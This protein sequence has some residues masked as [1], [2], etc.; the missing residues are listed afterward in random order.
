VLTNNDLRPITAKL[1]RWSVV[2]FSRKSAAQTHTSGLDG[3]LRYGVSYLILPVL[4][5]LPFDAISRSSAPSIPAIH[6]SSTPLYATPPVDK[7]V[8]TLALSVEWPTVG[9]HYHEADTTDAAG[10][11]ID[12][13][14]SNTTEY[15][16]YYDAESCYTYNNATEADQR[17]FDRSGA[18]TNRMCDDAFSGNFL[19]WASSSAIDMIRLALTG[20]DRFIDE[21]G[22]TILQRAVLPEAANNARS[23]MWNSAYFPAKLLMRTSGG[24][25]NAGTSFFGAI[26]RAMARAARLNDIW[27]AN[28]LD[29]IHFHAGTGPSGNCSDQRGYNL[30]EGILNN[31]GFFYARVQVCNTDSSGDLQ[32][33]RDYNLCTKYPDG[34]F[35]PTGAAQKYSEQ[36]RLAAFGYLMDHS[37]S[38]N[39][40]RYGGVLRAPMKYIGRKTFDI[41]GY[42]NTPP[43]G[44]PNR[45]WDT[46]TGVFLNNPDND[47]TYNRSGVINY[48]N[49]FGRTGQYKGNDPV[50]E[51]HYEALRYLQGLQ[52]SPDAISNITA[53]M[54]D[55]FPVSTRWTD[56]YAGRS[57]T[58]DYSC[59]KSNIVVIG[60]VGIHDG[61]RLP[62]PNLSNNV[63]DIDFWRK[64]VQSF[65]KDE[66]MEYTDGQGTLRMTGNPN[67]ANHAVPMGV[68]SNQIMG[69]AYWAHTHDIRGRNWT[70]SP[71]LQRP[72]LRVKTFIFDV[73]QFGVQNDFNR[74]HFANPLFMAAKYGGFETDP[75]SNNPFNTW[76]NPFLSENGTIDSS[77]WADS[78]DEARSYFMQSDG[79]SVLSAFDSIFNQASTAE[80]SIAGGAIASKTLT[81]SGTTIYQS[82][83]DTSDWSG[84]LLSFPVKVSTSNV[85]TVAPSATWSAAARLSA[86][87]TPARSR[88]I[89][90]GNTGAT[91]NPVAAPFTWDTPAGRSGIETSLRTAL[92]TPPPN[93]ATDNHARGRQNASRGSRSRATGTDGLGQDRLNY[94]RGDRS[95]EG[96]SF[97]TRQKL[98]GDIINSGIT[99][100]GIPSTSLPS[101]SFQAFLKANATRTPAVF[102]GANDGML[103]A[104][105]ATT[106]DELF[107]Y[108]PSWLGPRLSALTSTAYA[109]AHQSY[110]DATPVV[111]E[112]QTGSTGTASDWKTVLVSG[113]GGGGRGV[114]ALDVTNPAAFTASNVMWEFTHADD[115]DMGHVIGKPQILKFRTSAPGTGTP[116]YKWFAVVGSGVNN[117]LADGK[118]LNLSSGKPALF[119]LDLSKPV[120]TPWTLGQN[121]YKISLPTDSA[122]SITKA[123]GLV[124]FSAALNFSREV[125]QIYMGD[126]HGNLWKLDFSKRGSEDWNINKLSTFNM[127]QASHPIPLFIAKD[128]AG[129]VQPITMSPSITY[130]PTPLTSYILF[131]TGKYLER[132][133]KQSTTQQ[134]FYMLYDN[135]TAINDASPPG[136]SAISGR[137]RLREGTATRANASSSGR[138][139]VPAFAMGRATSDDDLSQRSGWYFDFPNSGE[140]SLSEAT[141]FGKQI[142]FG[143]LIPNISGSI[144]GCS[145]TIGGGAQYSLEI[146]DGS[147]TSRISNVG[148]M[149]EPLIAELSSATTTSKSDNAGRRIK[150]ITGQIIQQGSSGLKADDKT[151]RTVVSGRLS[152]RQINNYQDLRNA[153]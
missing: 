86:L 2:A 150:T 90:V 110:V 111:A 5:L 135:G 20:G 50:G 98:L 73:N 125:A 128:A 63:P 118:G 84:D 12:S 115:P 149:G 79:R 6:L 77:V 67:G 41:N 74:R 52:P 13:S 68:L 9:A 57:A 25:F 8:L 137:D 80:R 126:L 56:P 145:A 47:R 102:V 139:S 93:S 44:N 123:P 21:P 29:R 97:R 76:G 132:S 53:E 17:R 43:A 101:S 71:A 147:G 72:G 133:D 10:T 7:P 4:A 134:S 32:D 124:N 136:A 129:N 45:E 88:N 46:R 148:M 146:D 113:T 142:I 30:G 40:G 27:I 117:Y 152:W 55:D 103:H 39:G 70:Q 61:N 78:R 87:P 23:C 51:L 82:L 94:L 106:G 18:A 59:L 114:F 58:N 119:L 131:G 91:A 89:V 120:A 143:S 34:N 122:L 31:D 108:I 138:V 83:F 35:K 66:T 96:S 36:V 75:E 65:E 112:A 38:R 116:T 49:L 22:L 144:E 130:G 24:R 60:D 92:D 54:H 1:N 37:D 62:R 64:V 15:L 28:R 14:Y 95:K 69:S 140:R 11:W 42:E 127:G 81:K 16:G 107:A 153:P 105:N 19:N 121:Y 33:V 109:S 26:P 141:V 85:V 104:F 3:L 100:S 151:T 99:Y 48:L